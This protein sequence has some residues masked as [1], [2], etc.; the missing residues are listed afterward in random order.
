M[1]ERKR[2]SLRRSKRVWSPCP[3]GSRGTCASSA[4]LPVCRTA[5]ASPPAPAK[6]SRNLSAQYTASAT[7]TSCERWRPTAKS[8]AAGAAPA[9]AAP[10]PPTALAPS[11]SDMLG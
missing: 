10:P 1:S 11:A 3:E 9:G 6:S 2:S 8:P 4:S 7:K 5:A